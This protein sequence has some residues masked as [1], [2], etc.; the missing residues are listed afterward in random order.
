MVTA[1][2]FLAKLEQIPP[3]VGMGQ[4]FALAKA[5]MDM[6]LAEIEALLESPDHLARVG[7]VSIMDFQA[8]ARAG[9]QQLQ[10]WH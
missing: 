3:P 4:V 1:G 2:E 5:S 8:R 7:A 9:R 10:H 6:S